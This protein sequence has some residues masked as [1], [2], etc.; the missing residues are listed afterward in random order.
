MKAIS[1]V[2]TRVTGGAPKPYLREG[3]ASAPM[4]AFLLEP[5]GSGKTR[6]IGEAIRGLEAQGVTTGELCAL[7]GIPQRE[8]GMATRARLG[9]ELRELGWVPKRGRRG[10]HRERVY[11]PRAPLGSGGAE[12]AGDRGQGRSQ[13]YWPPAVLSPDELA[14]AGERLAAS[15]W[16]DEPG[17][18][19][20]CANCTGTIPVGDRW[21]R[22]GDGVAFWCGEIPPRGCAVR[23]VARG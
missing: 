13:R 11:R 12:A 23:E 14:A 5:Q 7:L 16:L 4:A 21:Q 9:E 1:R 20:L 19:L 17:P 18:R 6:R 15:S 3:R 10:L 8:R 22:A 2:L